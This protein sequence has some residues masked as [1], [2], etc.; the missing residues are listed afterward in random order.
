MEKK[1]SE[2][3]PQKDKEKIV[4]FIQEWFYENAPTAKAIVGISGG[5]DS[6]IVACLCKEA[7]GKERVVGVL[8]PNG[9]QKDFNDA[10][11][12]VHYLDIPY[13][14]VNIESSY[15][16][17]LK[18]LQIGKGLY[19]NTESNQLLQNL[20]PRLRMATLYAIGQGLTTGGIVINTCNYSE[21][22]IGYSTKFGDSA[23][24]ISP[25]GAYTVN[26]VLAIGDILD[27]PHYLVHKTP[28][29]GLCGK[30]DEDNLGFTY[31]I[32]DEYIKTGICED[33]EI[34]A[35]I[36]YRHKTNEH[37]LKPIP[38]VNR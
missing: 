24:D 7:L 33:K 15:N 34:K 9:I 21:D 20:A 18:Q 2:F 35:K 28:S 19:I 14:I 22:Y 36:D 10:L 13:K 30:T 32:L 26:E 25:L 38:I 11:E 16:A 1:Y 37:K 6:T 23:G 29:D 8:M 5:K 31:A 4:K 12:V 27:L 17:I 3:N